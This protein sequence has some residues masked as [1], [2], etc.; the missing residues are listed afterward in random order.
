M[1]DWIVDIFNFFKDFLPNIIG[2]LRTAVDLLI[3]S[4]VDIPVY[5]TMI[6]QPFGFILGISFCAIGICAFLRFFGSNVGGG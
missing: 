6:P 4:I 2:W 3:S 1:F 5:T